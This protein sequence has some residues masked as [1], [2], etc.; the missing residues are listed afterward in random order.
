MKGLVNIGFIW[1]TSAEIVLMNNLFFIVL[2]SICATPI[3]KTL[4]IKISNMMNG[5]KISK[6][7]EYVIYPFG[8]IAIFIGTFILL[9]G[10]SYNPF[11]YFRF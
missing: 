10:Q 5:G 2:A 9:V 1:D 11:L 6:V 7:Y 4:G 3:L 8:L